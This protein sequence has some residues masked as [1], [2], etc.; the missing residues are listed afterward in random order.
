MARIP[1]KGL[2]FES[3]EERQLLAVSA[4]EFEILRAGHPVLELSA[5]REDYNVIELNAD[6]LTAANL[7][8]ALTDAAGTEQNDLIVIRTT[9]NQNTIMLSGEELEIDSAKGTLTIV[10]LGGE[11]L[12]INADQKSRVFN[13]EDSTVFL[14]GMVI[15]G[16]YCGA[17]FNGSSGGGIWNHGTLTLDNVAVVKNHTDGFS[18]GGAGIYNAGTLVMNGCDVSGNRSG[19]ASGGGIRNEGIAVITNC[20]IAENSSLNSGGG[21]DNSGK[22]TICDSHVIEN[23]GGEGGGI[24]SVGAVEIVRCLIRG[25]TAYTGGGVRGFYGSLTIRDSVISLNTATTGGGI[26]CEGDLLITGTT[27]AGNHAEYGGGIC[28]DES[29]DPSQNPLGHIFIDNT[30]LSGNDAEY[31][32]GYYGCEEENGILPSKITLG[33]ILIAG[34]GG[35][36]EARFSPGCD[37]V[38]MDRQPV[39]VTQTLP[40][41]LPDD[42]LL[43]ILAYDR[44]LLQKNHHDSTLK[45]DNWLPQPFTAEHQ[46][47]LRNTVSGNTDNYSTSLFSNR[48]R[49]NPVWWNLWS[50]F[51]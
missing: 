2:H 20:T 18:G 1:S 37:V 16:G 47:M 21:I 39:P 8:N 41:Q 6:E 30:V 12:T 24:Y 7:Q 19:E 50:G 34:N 40:D 31:G 29:Y 26:A 27:I 35:S 49:N 3:L 25:N 14:S 38:R 43:N 28:A 11:K 13:I 32:G 10:S 15:T 42:R 45:W 17:F 36:E 5:G 4:V 22:L 48:E 44:R 46:A 51:A 23:R 33:N 9:K